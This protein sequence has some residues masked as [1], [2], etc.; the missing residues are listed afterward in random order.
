MIE[1]TLEF[2]ELAKENNV[3]TYELVL[4]D[5]TELNCYSNQDQNDFIKRHLFDDIFIVKE[6]LTPEKDTWINRDNV[7]L[8]RLNDKQ[9]GIEA[10]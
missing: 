8:L 2:L 1:P 10:I 3:F 6:V 7:Q 5:G 9:F 4:K